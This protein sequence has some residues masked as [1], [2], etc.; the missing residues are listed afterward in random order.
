MRDQFLVEITG[1]PDTIG[2]H[3]VTDLDELNRLLA[4]WTETVYHRTIHSETGQTPLQRWCAPGPV[5]LPAPE[6]LTEAFLWEAHRRVSKTATVALQGNS[7]EV[8]PAL[9]GRKVELVFDPF[10]L[11]RIEVRLAGVPMGLAIPH[12]I[13]RH[14]H[15]KA[16][17]ETPTAP[18]QPSGIDYAQLIET[19]HAAELARGVNYAALTAAAEAS[20]EIP[21][22]L[23]LLTGQEAQP[24]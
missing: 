9:V 10:D 21:G 7:Y 4:A 14:S 16:K 13:S 20:G 8:D 5:A 18:T 3:H 22:Q 12:H 2:R 11:T 19:A 6:A 24:K 15:P 23:D 1:E 17:P